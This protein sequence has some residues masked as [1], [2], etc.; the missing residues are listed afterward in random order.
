MENKTEHVSRIIRIIRKHFGILAAKEGTR[1]AALEIVAYME[2]EG[3]GERKKSKRGKKARVRTAGPTPDTVRKGPG[4]NGVR[5]P[6]ETGVSD[7]ERTKDEHAED[8]P[9][10]KVNAKKEVPR[11]TIHNERRDS[12]DTAGD[13]EGSAGQPDDRDS[14]GRPDTAEAGGY[15]DCSWPEGARG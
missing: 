7:R 13:K 3:S 2:K 4:R 6:T 10:E 8:N 14:G 1:T 5:R 12:S 15:S 9:S 11:E